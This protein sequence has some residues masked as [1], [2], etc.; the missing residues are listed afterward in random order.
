MILK[1]FSVSECIIMIL[2]DLLI[3]FFV[4]SLEKSKI[5][6]VCE[7]GDYSKAWIL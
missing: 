2:L 3:C 1:H 4:F 5:L 6:S 7:S